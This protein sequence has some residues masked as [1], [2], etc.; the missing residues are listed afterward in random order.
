MI[1]CRG[2]WLNYIRLSQISFFSWY[3]NLD[4][5]FDAKAIFVEEN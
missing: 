3:I 1:G 4:G 5:L 2:K